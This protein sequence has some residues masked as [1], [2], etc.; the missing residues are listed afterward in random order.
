MKAAKIIYII[1]NVIMI[2]AC[3]VLAVVGIING[4]SLL[5]LIAPIIAVALF[6]VV[7]FR[8]NADGFINLMWIIFSAH[9]A[10]IIA[11]TQAVFVFDVKIGNAVAMLIIAVLLIAFMVWAISRMFKKLAGLEKN[12]DLLSEK[13]END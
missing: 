3:T 1:M 11:V 13:K 12:D 4:F 6:T 9:I 10:V 5:Y 7:I 8:K 2:L